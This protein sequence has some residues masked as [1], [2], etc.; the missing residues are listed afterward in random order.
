MPSDRF[1][2]LSDSAPRASAPAPRACRP[3]L[4]PCLPWPFFVGHALSAATASGRRLS[5]FCRSEPFGDRLV[6][7]REVS[8]RLSGFA[9]VLRVVRSVA[10][11]IPGLVVRRARFEIGDE[12]V[13]QRRVSLVLGRVC[14]VPSGQCTMVGGDG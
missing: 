9:R 7:L 8:E 4:W 10:G 14:A 13:V 11:E 1:S 3:C 12:R 5:R 6:V 2:A